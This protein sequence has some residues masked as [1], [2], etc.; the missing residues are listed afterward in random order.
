MRLITPNAMRILQR[1]IERRVVVESYA[2]YD[3]SKKGLP[4]PDFSRWNWSQANEIDKVMASAQLKT[5]VPAGYVL[6]DKVELTF[7][8]L[9]ESAVVADIFPNQ[10][11]KLGLIE[12]AGQLSGWKPKP[13][14]SWY[15]NVVNGHAFDETAPFLLRPALRNEC[16]ASWYM[17][18][19]S[20]RAVAIVANQQK[21]SSQVVGIGYLGRKPDM[22]NAFMQRGPFGQLLTR[23]NCE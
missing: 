17:E 8:D 5:G 4:I 7:S 6:W 12:S 10:S 19:G 2:R 3:C 21:F 16:P 13:E 15:S 1:D 18:D 23:R 20:G 9:R 14:R 11:R 22:S